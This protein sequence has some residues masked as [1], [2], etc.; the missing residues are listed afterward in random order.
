MNK[1]KVLSI[2]FG[3]MAVLLSIVMCA[4]VAYNYC[5]MLWGAKYEGYSAPANISFYL[6]VPY[7]LG[8]VIC[9]VLMLFFKKKY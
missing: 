7:I 9:V 2:V 3:I 8:I 4:V 5:S 1:F 6:A